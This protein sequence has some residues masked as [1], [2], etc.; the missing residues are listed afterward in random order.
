MSK[1][2]DKPDGAAPRKPSTESDEVGQ[3]I[4]D[5]TY[6]LTHDLSNTPEDLRD[7]LAF[8][9]LA[10]IKL[11]ERCASVLAARP[12]RT[13]AAVIALGV[14]LTGIALTWRKKT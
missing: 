11:A 3:A 12:K 5:V 7:A 2:I 6:R 14:V 8:G 10:A 13:L 9:P 1:D 4:R